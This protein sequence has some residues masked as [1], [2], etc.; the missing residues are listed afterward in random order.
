M[1]VDDPRRLLHQCLDILNK[2][3]NGLP[4]R[5][6]IHGIHLLVGQT[7]ARRQL[8]SKRGFSG[9]GNSTH[10]NALHDTHASRSLS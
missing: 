3:R 5:A 2:G 6:V 9:T 8:L 4:V 1:G 10:E 7:Q